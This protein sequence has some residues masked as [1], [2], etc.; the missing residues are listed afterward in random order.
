MSAGEILVEVTRGIAVE[1]RH[2]GSVAVSD[3]AGRLVFALGDVARPTFPRSAVKALQALPLVESGAAAR[4]GFSDEELALACASHSGE[5]EHVATAAG[6]LARLGLGAEALECGAH[7]P[8]SDAAAR[9][10]A[11]SGVGPTALHNNCSGK[12][13]GFLCLACAMEVEP[14]GYIQPEHP[15][16]REVTAALEGALG[17]SLAEAAVGVDGCGIPTYAAPLGAVAHA[18]ARFATGEGFGPAR[19]AAAKTLMRAAWS[20]PFQVAGTGRFDTEAM[21]ALKD[22]AFVK[23]GAEGVHVA[24]LPELGFGVALKIEDGATRGAEVAMAA[25]LA[26]L[27]RP[28]GEQ[29]AW[30]AS[31]M[32]RRLINWEGVE[33]GE[34]RPGPAL[35][36]A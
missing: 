17:M 34:L 35:S 1:S 24:A 26:R 21:Q 19:A 28:E 16:Q 5:P 15:V 22:R 36:A 13:A 27:L 18:F 30:L 11:A 8:T 2:A 14:A 6:A 29:A 7:W 33:V 32:R 9:A 25:V 23:M 4:F 20:A 10:L 3:A 31:R 12:H